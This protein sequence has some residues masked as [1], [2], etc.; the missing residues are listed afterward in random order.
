[1]THTFCSH[2]GNSI[3]PNSHFCTK[4][5]M[6]IE[7]EMGLT[8]KEKGQVLTSE[9]ISPKSGITTLL[10][11]IFLGTLGIHRFY[12]GKIGTGILMLLTCGG[13]GIWT[14]VDLVLIASCNFK[15]KNG[16]VLIF[17][18]SQ[19]SP[20]KLILTVIGGVIAI[21]IVYVMLL[22][23]LVLYA[24]SGLT[25]T[26]NNQLTALR[27]GDIVKAY[28]YTSKAF[29]AA[30]SLDDFKKFVDQYSEL[31]NNKSVSFTDREF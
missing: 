22:V 1:M 28:S 15:D 11:C 26:V 29:Q 16:N 10:L 2:C 27:S 12:V 5:G 23:M 13:L 24:T 25:E 7:S 20:V 8:E 4:C 6:K 18:K 31:K 30:V 19:K 14:L 21:I 17:K 9:S 3:E